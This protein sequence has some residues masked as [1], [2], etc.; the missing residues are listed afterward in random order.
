MHRRRS[1]SAG[2]LLRTVLHGNHKLAKVIAPDSS[3]PDTATTIRSNARGIG[4]EVATFSA[5][6]PNKFAGFSCMYG[7]RLI[8]RQGNNLLMNC[9]QTAQDSPAWYAVYSTVT[10]SIVAATCS[11][12]G[13]A[14][15]PN[16][17]GVNH[18]QSLAGDTDWTFIG[19]NPYLRHSSSVTSGNS[20]SV[21]I[22][23]PGKYR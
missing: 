3:M 9:L 12:C 13:Q 15:A 14:M 10:N 17:W 16:R 8:G 6:D 2:R 23:M 20:H 4:A 19:M 18:A 11:Y 5:S 22:R 7:W 1:R 21:T